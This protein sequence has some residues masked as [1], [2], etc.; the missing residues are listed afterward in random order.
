MS[1]IA[2]VVRKRSKGMARRGARTAAA[3]PRAPAGAARH[4]RSTQGTRCRRAE[5]HRQ[6]RSSIRSENRTRTRRHDREQTTVTDTVAARNACRRAS[7]VRARATSTMDG[8]AGDE[9]V[10][11][12]L[13]DVPPEVAE[14]LPGVV[15]PLADGLVGTEEPAT[16]RICTTSATAR[17]AEATIPYSQRETHDR[18]AQASLRE[19]REHERREPGLPGRVRPPAH[20]LRTRRP[21]GGRRVADRRRERGG[22]GRAASDED[23]D[24]ERGRAGRRRSRSSQVPV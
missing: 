1:V 16:A 17:R 12:E 4:A 10:Q 11:G 23:E 3:T 7:R 14:R 24:H 2:E 8:R 5:R 19:D 15:R 22:G 20:G 13:R 9:E 18:L 6:V 21:V